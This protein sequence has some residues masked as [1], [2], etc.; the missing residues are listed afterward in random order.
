MKKILLLISL[1]LFSSVLVSA[2][3][4]IIS[5]VYPHIYFDDDG[6]NGFYLQWIYDPVYSS[7]IIY[8]IDTDMNMELNSSEQEMAKDDF[9]S[10]LKSEDWFMTIL[11]NG[12]KQVIPEP[13]NFS[14]EI[15]TFDETIMF[16]FYIPLS[17][18]YETSG[19]KVNIEFTD[20]S[21]YTAFKIPVESLKANGTQATINSVDINYWGI[22]EYDFS[23]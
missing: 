22:V 23:R 4:H 5:M 19:T 2:H 13:V 12:E 9:I 1:L 21:Q 11:V 20:P 16:T 3:P 18:P 14:A 17:L 8:D 15:D 7:Q 10:A 6:M